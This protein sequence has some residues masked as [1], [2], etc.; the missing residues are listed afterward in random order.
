[1]FEIVACARTATETPPLSLVEARTRGPSVDE[2]PPDRERG[3]RP[4]VRKAQHQSELPKNEG[5]LTVIRRLPSEHQAPSPHQ[6][7]GI[8]FEPN[9]HDLLIKELLQ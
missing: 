9:I 3:P 4:N 7:F 5:R 6:L 2:R 1:M 8:I